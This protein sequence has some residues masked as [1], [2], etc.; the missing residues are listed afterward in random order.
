MV[1]YRLGAFQHIWI[2]IEYRIDKNSNKGEKN[3]KKGMCSL[4]S[5]HNLVVWR[6][7]A[8]RCITKTKEIADIVKP[9]IIYW[10][11]VYKHIYITFLFESI[12]QDRF[13]IVYVETPLMDISSFPSLRKMY[14]P[15][16]DG[17]S[18]SMLLSRH[19][20]FDLKSSF[21]FLA[22]TPHHEFTMNV[23]IDQL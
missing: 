6:G 4:R 21:F 11:K 3:H 13:N 18:E 19:I 1:L 2:L 7:Q 23:F 14:L 9:I 22:A 15:V 10:L 8:S 12:F 17:S 5:H 16:I 20:I